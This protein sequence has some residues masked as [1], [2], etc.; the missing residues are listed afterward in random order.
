MEG[1]L[2]TNKARVVLITASIGRDWLERLQTLSPDLRIEQRSARSVEAV[3]DALWQEVEIL[4]TSFATPL[5]LPEQAPRL[6]WVQLYSAGPDRILD[7]PLTETP[8]IFTTTS[9]IHAINIAEHVLT[10]VLAWLHRFRRLTVRYERRA[11]VHQAFVTL[12]C[13]LICWNY[14][15]SPRRVF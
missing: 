14:L 7:H 3:P 4:F 1:F 5:P 6:H 11:D 8:V 2:V 13:V 9:G 12:G 10:M 15:K